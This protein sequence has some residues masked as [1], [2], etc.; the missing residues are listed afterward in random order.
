MKDTSIPR[1]SQLILVSVFNDKLR[2]SHDY[3]S[4]EPGSTN[5]GLLARASLLMGSSQPGEH[6]E[7]KPVC[8]AIKNQLKLKHNCA[9]GGCLNGAQ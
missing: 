1:S 4:L 8:L 5:N 2:W 6:A 7:S 3:V 9:Y